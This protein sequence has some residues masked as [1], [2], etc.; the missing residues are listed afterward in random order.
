[1]YDKV[2]IQEGNSPDYILR[3]LKIF[4]KKKGGVLIIML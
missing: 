3:F 4:G 1:M 2:L